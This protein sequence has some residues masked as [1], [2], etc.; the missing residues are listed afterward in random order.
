MCFL[1]MMSLAEPYEVLHAGGAALSE[2]FDVIYL[3]S[4]AHVACWYLADPI[5]L[6]VSG[7]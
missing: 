5:S 4:N 3:E 1:E 6:L 7:A 2:G